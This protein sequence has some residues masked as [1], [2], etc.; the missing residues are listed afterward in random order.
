MTRILIA[1]ILTANWLIC[2]EIQVGSAVIMTPDLAGQTGITSNTRQFSIQESSTP[3]TNRLLYLS[4]PTALAD[5]ANSGTLVD[6][7]N[8][9]VIQSFRQAE[10]MDISAEMFKGLTQQ[11]AGGMTE[12][13]DEISM[14]DLQQTLDAQLKA[15][16]GIDSPIKLGKPR[17]VGDIDQT[18]GKVSALMLIDVAIN[19][20]PKVFACRFT[21]LTL[22]QRFIYV[23]SYK[24]VSGA[25]SLAAVGKQHEDFLAALHQANAPAP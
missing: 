13:L 2:A 7:D 22:R 15:Q 10:H 1:L 6:L 3:A 19:D 11:I 8:F 21:I 12:A 23:Y 4:A 16:Q 17:L 25:D 24:S 9:H 20:E 14:E 5:Q 18:G